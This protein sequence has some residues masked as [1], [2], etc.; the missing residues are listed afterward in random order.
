MKKKKL[1]ILH[2]N[3]GS[4]NGC[5]I[6]ILDVLRKQEAQEKIEI[7]ENINEIDLALITGIVNLKTQKL[8]KKLQNIKKDAKIIAVGSC[9][10]S[11]GVFQQ[12]YNFFGPT[13]KFVAIDFY[14]P[15]CPPHPQKITEAI[16]RAYN[17]DLKS[18]EK[19]TE[20]FRGKV[21]YDPSKCIKCFSCVRS[22]PASAIRFL[23]ENNAL[24]FEYFEDR[25]IFCGTCEFVCPQGAIKLEN[26]AQKIIKDKNQFIFRVKK[27]EI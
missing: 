16:N 24:Y 21:I 6:E 1:K 14:V 20:K 27:E 3:V 9:A 15:G 18:K 17:L 11:G 12:S 25:C 19:P 10:I 23:R 5:D 13:N 4:C 26:K 2:L 22:C 7:T 8:I